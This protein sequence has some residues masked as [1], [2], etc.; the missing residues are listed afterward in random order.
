MHFVWDF[1]PIAI[2]I[3]FINV[4]IYWYGILFAA[5]F[6]IGYYCV[7]IYFKKQNLDTKYLDSLMLY[8]FLGTIIGARLAHCIFYDPSYYFKNP[9]SILKIWEGGLA[10]HGGGIGLTIST[11]LFCKKYKINFLEL[12]D[13]LVIPTAFVGSLI[14]IGNFLNSE[15]YGKATD[16]EYGVIF[17]ALKDNIYRHPVQLYESFSYILI[18][19]ILLFT[20]NKV[21]YKGF[22]LGL[23]LILIFIT[24]IILEYFKP[25]QAT[26]EFE[27]LGFTVGQLLSLPFIFIGFIIILCSLIKKN[28]SNYLK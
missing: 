13:L 15:I 26:Y 12:A 6:F 1:N 5:G 16:S 23:F 20:F 14:R 25:E 27:F 19:L 11:L 9:L 18:T 21:K 2:T 22:N 24:R 7:S 17:A 28:K 4:C 3:P 10:S 8:M